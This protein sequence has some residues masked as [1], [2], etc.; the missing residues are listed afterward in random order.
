MRSI[1]KIGCLK[2]TQV[3]KNHSTN[4]L[5]GEIKG[6]G[7]VDQVVLKLTGI[8]H[9]LDECDD[10]DIHPFRWEQNFHWVGF[11][12]LVPVVSEE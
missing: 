10:W 4:P 6:G 5:R 11:L 3:Q 8:F 7:N 9:D 1:S 12:S 2:P